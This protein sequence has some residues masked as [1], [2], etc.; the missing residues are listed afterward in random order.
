MECSRIFSISGRFKSI[1]RLYVYGIG[2][3]IRR[4][5]DL[6]AGGGGDYSIPVVYRDPI[7]SNNGYCWAMFGTLKKTFCKEQRACM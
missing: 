4:L 6:V 1:R 2:M 3:S 5:Y 7:G